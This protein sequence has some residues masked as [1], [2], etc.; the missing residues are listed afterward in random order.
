M[1]NI[2]FVLIIGL[3]GIAASCAF[4]VKL[5]RFIFCYFFLIKNSKPGRLFT[6]SSPVLLHHWYFK[7]RTINEKHQ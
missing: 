5:L 7:L 3:L 2:M 1:R 4:I 6:S